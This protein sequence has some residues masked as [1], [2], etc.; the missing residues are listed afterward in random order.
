MVNMSHVPT[1]VM[2]EV[3]IVM[4]MIVNGIGGVAVRRSG[5]DCFDL[6]QCD[7]ATGTPR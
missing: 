3:V 5:G 6:I 2:I 7:N 4:A 1:V